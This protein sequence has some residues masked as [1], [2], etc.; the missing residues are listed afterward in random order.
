MDVDEQPFRRADQHAREWTIEVKK[1][2]GTDS[3]HRAWLA[4]RTVLHALRDR[5]PV[6]EVAQV[7]AQLPMLVRGEFYTG[8]S[9]ARRRKRERRLQPFLDQIR[10]AFKD[11]PDVDP[12]EITRLVFGVLQARFTAGEIADLQGLLPKHIRELW[13]GGGGDAGAREVDVTAETSPGS[14]H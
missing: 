4:L 12:A 2:L 7:G 6:T 5:L 3:T 1:A 8:W 9:P 13:P 10:R 14:E 11:E